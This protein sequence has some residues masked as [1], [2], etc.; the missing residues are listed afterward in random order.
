MNIKGDFLHLRTKQTDREIPYCNT[1]GVDRYPTQNLDVLGNTYNMQIRDANNFV[2]DEEF[3]ESEPSLRYHE[4]ICIR[5]DAEYPFRKVFISKSYRFI[6]N[7]QTKDATEFDPEEYIAVYCV[8]DIPL[9]GITGVVKFGYE[10]NDNMLE[11]GEHGVVIMSSLH[12]NTSDLI[13]TTVGDTYKVYDGSEV[14]FDIDSV[15][16]NYESS[17]TPEMMVAGIRKYYMNGRTPYGLSEDINP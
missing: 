14:W 6:I 5:C 11:E 16:P 15:Q 4:V 9:I 10:Y 2:V 12:E 17:I 1:I 3:P 7:Y 13:I 8:Q